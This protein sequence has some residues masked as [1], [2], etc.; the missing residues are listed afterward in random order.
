[1]SDGQTR[2]C[3]DPSK[4]YRLAYAT[5]GR[6]LHRSSMNYVTGAAL[7]GQ[8]FVFDQ[9]QRSDRHCPSLLWPEGSGCCGIL[10]VMRKI[11]VA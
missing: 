6:R 4:R 9:S 2:A 7:I 1:M 8:C 5:T 10:R 11:P 3:H